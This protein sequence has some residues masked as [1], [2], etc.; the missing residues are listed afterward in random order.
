MTKLI[1]ALVLAAAGSMAHAAAPRALEVSCDFIQGRV[2]RQGW[3]SVRVAD[4]G[5]YHSTTFVKS[6]NDCFNNDQNAYGVSIETATG[7]CYL[8]ACFDNAWEAGSWD[9]AN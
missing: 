8:N 4:A 3:A 9:R 5:P 6:D 1:A 7:K 2:A